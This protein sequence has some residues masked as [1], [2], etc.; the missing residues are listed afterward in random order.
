[1]CSK[2]V[3]HVHFHGWLFFAFFSFVFCLNISFIIITFV[4]KRAR[5][6]FEGLF[7]S[8]HVGAGKQTQVLKLGGKHVFN[9]LAPW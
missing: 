9:L 8:G 1:M 2:C 3:K 7:F 6:D 5:E 4:C